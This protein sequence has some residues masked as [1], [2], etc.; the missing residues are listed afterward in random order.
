MSRTAFPRWKEIADQCDA[1]DP[2]E[3]YLMETARSYAYAGRMIAAVGTPGFTRYSVKIYGRPDHEYKTQKLTAIDAAK[4]FLEVTDNLLGNSNIT[5]AETDISSTDFAGW[6]KTEVDEFFEHDTV[7]V[8]I[9]PNMASKALVGATRI[10]V[11]GS[12]VLPN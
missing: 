1:G 4:F 6:L 5:P 12:A 11:R 10:R 9:D 2:V 8:V 7:E 3:K